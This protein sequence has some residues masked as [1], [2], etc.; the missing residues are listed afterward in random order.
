MRIGV[1]AAALALFVAAHGPQAEP[2]AMPPLYEGLE[3]TAEVLEA[4]AAFVAKALASHGNDP[5]RA[6]QTWIDIAWEAIGNGDGETAVRRLNQAYLIRPNEPGVPF[7]LMIATHVRGDDPEVTDRFYAQ[8]LE[9]MTPAAQK[10]AHMDY[11]RIL[12]ERGDFPAAISTVRLEAD[13]PQP[14]IRALE[15]LMHLCNGIGDHQCF[16]EA[17]MRFWERREEVSGGIGTN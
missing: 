1:L 2:F 15:L 5:V 11:A 10:F 12:G 17:N 9:A 16:E 13:Q 7:G 3:K 6:A 8:S 4:D 14:D